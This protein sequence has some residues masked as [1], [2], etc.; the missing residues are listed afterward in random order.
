LSCRKLGAESCAGVGDAKVNSIDVAR[1]VNLGIG[2]SAVL[3]NVLQRLLRDPKQAQSYILRN[4]S[5]NVMVD[6]PDLQAVLLRKFS[7]QAP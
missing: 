5:R 4:L 2:G 7:T 6:K 1:Q 3:H